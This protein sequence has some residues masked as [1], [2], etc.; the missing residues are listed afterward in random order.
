MGA[1]D[2]PQA[3]LGE[4]V[5]GRWA[6]QDHEAL[7]GGQPARAFAAQVGGALGEEGRVN[8]DHPLPVALAHHLHLAH[9]HVHIGQPQGSDLRRPQAAEHHGEG[10]GP[11][12]VGAQVGDEGGHLG[13]LQGLGQAA[14]L[15]HQT[16]VGAGMA[17][18]HVAE[19]ASRPG[20]Q[21]GGTARGGNGVLL[22]Q[23]AND[24]VFEQSPDR[25]DP[26]VHGGWRRSPAVVEANHLGAS[27]GPCLALPVQVIEEV[28]GDHVFHRGAPPG[29]E[30]AEVQQVESVSPHRARGEPTGVQVVEIV[31]GHPRDRPV[32]GQAVTACCTHYG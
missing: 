23:P 31:V 29:E 1:E 9:A 18:P 25:S 6:P 4:R 7:R 14:G 12:P 26:A 2:A 24:G 3:G 15:A 17:G 5:S 32:A 27:G 8:R 19:Q 11:V 20:P 28:R 10:H 16:A 21:P 13:R 30:P 22:P